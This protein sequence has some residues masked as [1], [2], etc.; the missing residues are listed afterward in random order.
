MPPSLNRFRSWLSDD[1]DAYGAGG[2]PLSPM[3]GGLDLEMGRKGVHYSAGGVPAIL[4]GLDYSE[5]EKMEGA[6]VHLKDRQSGP[7]APDLFMISAARQHDVGC[8]GGGGDR[9]PA[10]VHDQD[11]ERTLVNSNTNSER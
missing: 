1:E 5:M 10:I 8:G 7:E 6:G 4:Q 9:S 3:S 11:A 2:G